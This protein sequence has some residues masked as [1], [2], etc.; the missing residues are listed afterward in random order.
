MIVIDRHPVKFVAGLGAQPGCR[1]I[2]SATSSWRPS[3][4]GL[5]QDV[6]EDLP[7]LGS[8][9]LGA[10]VRRVD[11]R[12]GLEG[13]VWPRRRPRSPPDGRSSR[14]GGGGTGDRT[15]FLP[16]WRARPISRRGKSLSSRTLSTKTA[17]G[18][19]RSR[20][21]PAR[22]FE[23]CGAPTRLASSSPSRITCSITVFSI[24]ARHGGVD[25]RPRLTLVKRNG[26]LA[27]PRRRGRD[28]GC[29]PASA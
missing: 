6:R 5:G 27:R 24:A 12:V 21:L 14:T 25:L 13:S 17:S 16:P 1:P 23:W 11:H 9:V 2:R 7:L 15:H 10:V 19:R 28:T 26:P 3:R 20:R 29:F 8:E 18:R 22:I 4:L